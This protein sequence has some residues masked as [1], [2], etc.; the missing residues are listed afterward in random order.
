[1]LFNKKNSPPYPTKTVTYYIP[2]PPNRK[3]GYQETE[4]DKLVM[5]LTQKEFIIEDIKTQIISNERVQGMWVIF[6]IKPTT[7]QSNSIDLTKILETT[8]YPTSPDIE[9]DI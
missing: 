1:M 5:L 8:T 3:T 9:Y 7:S 6:L 4:I 2:A